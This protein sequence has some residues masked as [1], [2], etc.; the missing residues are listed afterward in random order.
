MRLTSILFSAFAFF[1]VSSATAVYNISVGADGQY[2]Y[3]P[4]LYVTFYNSVYIWF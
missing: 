3:V 2:A 4:Q 1:S